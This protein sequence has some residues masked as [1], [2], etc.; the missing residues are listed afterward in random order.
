VEGL[1]LRG[2]SIYRLGSMIWTKG[3][4]PYLPPFPFGGRSF[5]EKS[6]LDV[7]TNRP[8]QEEYDRARDEWMTAARESRHRK[9]AQ[10][11]RLSPSGDEGRGAPPG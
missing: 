3:K 1:H 6:I 4:I 11:H 7:L 8:T 2:L 9:Q 10:T 5:D